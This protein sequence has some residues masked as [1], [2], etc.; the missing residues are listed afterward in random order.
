MTVPAIHKK[1]YINIIIKR[2]ISNDKASVDL[3]HFFMFGSAPKVQMRISISH[4]SPNQFYC[5]K[6]RKQNTRNLHA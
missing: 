5:I 6:T 3:F 4:R 2:D 1:I